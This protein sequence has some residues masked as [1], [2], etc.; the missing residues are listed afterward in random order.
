M[1]TQYHHLLNELWIQNHYIGLIPNKSRNHSQK[2]FY[3][4]KE[5]SGQDLK[6]HNVLTFFQYVHLCIY[7]FENRFV[8]NKSDFSSIFFIELLSSI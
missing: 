5:S 1:P 2:K 4:Y 6:K 3:Y 8:R 7:R